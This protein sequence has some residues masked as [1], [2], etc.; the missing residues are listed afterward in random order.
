MT[1]PYCPGKALETRAPT[2]YISV[3]K[4]ELKCAKGTFQNLKSQVTMIF[5]LRKIRVVGTLNNMWAL[6]R[7]VVVNNIRLSHRRRMGGESI[8]EKQFPCF[9]LS[10]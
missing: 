8:V 1:A 5:S 9:N 7:C 2:K 10:N 3:N 6:R 4:T